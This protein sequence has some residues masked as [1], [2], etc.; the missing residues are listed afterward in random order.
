[1]KKKKKKK[2]HKHKHVMGKNER[3]TKQLQLKKHRLFVVTAGLV[4]SIATAAFG[5]RV[6]PKSYKEG[7]D[8]ITLFLFLYPNQFVE[9]LSPIVVVLCRRAPVDLS[10][11]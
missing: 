9:S 10:N 8:S 11:V 2:K 6:I 3:K 1:M 7:T 5:R 4:S